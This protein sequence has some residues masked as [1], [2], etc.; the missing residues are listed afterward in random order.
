[1]TVCTVCLLKVAAELERKETVQLLEEELK[2]T[3]EEIKNLNEEPRKGSRKLREKLD[4]ANLASRK[5]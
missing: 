4:V 3:K 1:M 2:N 5:V